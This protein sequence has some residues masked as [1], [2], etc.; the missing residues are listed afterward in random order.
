MVSLLTFDA[1][2]GVDDEAV[3]VVVDRDV[4]V[5]VAD[6]L[7]DEDADDPD[8]YDDD[9][10]AEGR[11]REAGFLLF[12]DDARDFFFLRD[13]LAFER[14]LL[15]ERRELFP[16]FDRVSLTRDFIAKDLL[17]VERVRRDLLEELDGREGA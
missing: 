13:D 8:E 17:A 5:A 1:A 7:V 6:L 3:L 2:G 15:G 14:G 11:L 4:V 16:L 10:D 12:F 9:D